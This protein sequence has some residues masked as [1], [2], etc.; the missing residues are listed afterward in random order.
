MKKKSKIALGSMVLM[1]LSVM[2]ACSSG[3]GNDKKAEV[4]P[5]STASTTAAPQKVHDISTISYIY[6]TVPPASGPAVDAIKTKFNANIKP[7]FVPVADFAA[8]LN[9]LVAS[10]DMP[11]VVS[12]DN[13]NQTYYKWA[14]QGAFLQLDEYIDKY[15]TLKAI[16]KEILDQFRVNGKL[17]GI[18][19]FALSYERGLLIRQDWLNNLGLKMPSNYEE[20]LQVA[21][22]FTKQDPDQNGKNDTYG[23]ASSSYLN[24]DF[25][26]GAWWS[27]AWY[28][29]DKDGNLIP[30][31][32]GPGRK[33]VVTM[34]A[35]A[36]KQGA[37]T[38]DFLVLDWAATNKEFYS[39]K[40]GIF[41]G[42]LRG[43]PKEYLDLKKLDPKAE[44]MPVPFFVQPD[45]K[46]GNNTGTGYNGTVSLNAKLK[47]DPDKI[48]KILEMLD[49]GRKWI[50]LDQRT[51]QNKDFDWL[52][53]GDGKGYDMVDGIAVM[54]PNAEGQR[55]FHYL[56]ARAE[57]FNPWKPANEVFDV[58]KTYADA[59]SK[60]YM[61]SLVDADVNSN[62]NSYYDPSF[63]VY[64]ETNAK[65]GNQLKGFLNEEQMKM[66]AGQRP[67]SDWD[68]MIDEWK[69]QGGDKLVKEINEGIKAKGA[70]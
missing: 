11:D 42:S 28:H 48:A 49:Y 3:D 39:G 38:K 20:L 14:E 33:E 4:T 22:A 35:E 9:V 26:S 52:A 29:K 15:P 24:P 1:S 36:Y 16:P 47:S 56:I 2:S 44:L 59:E 19:N 10:G 37:M 25:A 18:P 51:P 57:T 66:I 50:S 64:S 70:K 7:Q 60:K 53:G 69:A 5:G 62:K 58:S 17:Y 63:G 45:G 40:A 30:G 6:G 54:K 68:K 46:Q 23:F 21:I 32:A 13:P 31:E 55:P 65:L 8:K 67:L 34:L 61:K 27:K 12:G 43:T 41:V